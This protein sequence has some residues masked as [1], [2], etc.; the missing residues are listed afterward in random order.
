MGSWSLGVDGGSSSG[1]GAVDDS[2]MYTFVGSDAGLS[3]SLSLSD[4]GEPAAGLRSFVR[5]SAPLTLLL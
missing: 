3:L 1:A 2:S 4:G 5:S